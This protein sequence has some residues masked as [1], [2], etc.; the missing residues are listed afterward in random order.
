MRQD[1]AFFDKETT[2]REVVGRMSGDTVLIQDVM[3]EKLV[4]SQVSSYP[5]WQL[6]D[7][8]LILKLRL[9][10]SRL[11]AQLELSLGQASPCMTALAAARAAAF[12]MFET[13]NRK[14]EIYAFDTN[15]KILND[16]RV[17]L[18]GESGSG[19]STVISLIEIFYDPESGEVLIDGINLKE[20]QLKW[21]WEKIGL[22]SQEPVLLTCSIK[23]NI[24]TIE[25][26]R[27][28]AELANAAKFI[29]KLPQGLGM[30]V[31]EHGTQLPGG[32][33]QRVA[34][35]GAILK[36]PRILLL[37]EATRAP[38]TESERI[39]QEALDRIMVNR[40]TVIVAHRL[41]IVSNADI[42]IVTI[43]IS[44]RAQW[45][46]HNDIVTL[47]YTYEF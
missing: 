14:P 40:T 39:V 11:L 42:V 18:V 6:M 5:K 9:S 4:Q 30:M 13:I 29:D 44:Y 2:T 12:K 17:A 45:M 41:S 38:D 19:K 31:G 28:A 16:I 21:I 25:E 15:E 10:L 35:A 20:F 27:V 37:D 46:G 36:N 7:K 26:I 23:D 47:S 3:G 33:N 43:I 8:M 34:I 24:A 1:I 22:V 32:Q